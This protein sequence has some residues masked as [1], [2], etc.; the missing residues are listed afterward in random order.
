MPRETSKLP[1][2][3]FALFRAKETRVAACLLDQGTKLLPACPEK[4][5]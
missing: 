1:G 3:F 4:I 5:G 2:P